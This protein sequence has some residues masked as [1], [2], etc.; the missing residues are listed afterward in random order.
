MFKLLVFLCFVSFFSSANPLKLTPLCDERVTK[1]GKQVNSF[2]RIQF[3]GR[4]DTISYYLPDTTKSQPSYEASFNSQFRK[5]IKEIYN[6]KFM[7]SSRLSDNIREKQ[8]SLTFLINQFRFAPS[9]NNRDYDRND[10]YSRDYLP[11]STLYDIKRVERLLESLNKLSNNNLTFDFLANNH[12]GPSNNYDYNYYGYNLL[13]R[14]LMQLTRL[15]EGQTSVFGDELIDVFY[16]KSL[17]TFDDFKMNRK[18]QLFLDEQSYG[19]VSFS[20]FVPF[21]DRNHSQNVKS[22]CS[23]IGDLP[24]FFSLETLPDKQLK[25][26]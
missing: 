22:N 24:K 2:H 21:H 4:L 11:S 6:E 20:L 5:L 7:N 18:N 12:Y 23:S 10:R 16:E 3:R 25:V 15:D 14:T 17:A 26:N 8:N 19:L 1:D 9:Y 13:E